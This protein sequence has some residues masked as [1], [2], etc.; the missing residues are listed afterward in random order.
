MNVV[1]VLLFNNYFA[2]I[3]ENNLQA[4]CGPILDQMETFC[5]NSFLSVKLPPGNVSLMQDVN[6]TE[7]S[8]YNIQLLC[9]YKTHP[10]L[11]CFVLASN[12]T[13]K[14]LYFPL[15]SIVY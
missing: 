12:Q 13:N 11:K 5:G 4:I 3:S 15:P 10:T 8:C 9:G 6:Q 14:D 2:T 1:Y 7:S